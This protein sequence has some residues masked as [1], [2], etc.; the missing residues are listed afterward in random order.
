[1]PAE[2][3]PGGELSEASWI[4][5]VESWARESPAQGRVRLDVARGH[6]GLANSCSSLITLF[7]IRSSC[8]GSWGGGGV[9]V[10]LAYDPCHH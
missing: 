8:T 4:S 3:V 5:L 7:F 9:I 6:V 10:N 2:R 1:M